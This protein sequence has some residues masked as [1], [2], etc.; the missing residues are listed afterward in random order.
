[1]KR[2]NPEKG[3][4]AMRKPDEKNTPREVSR[5]QFLSGSV[6]AVVATSAA[7]LGGASVAAYAQQSGKP[8]GG[9]QS[10]EPPGG[11]YNYTDG[12]TNEDVTWWKG[13]RVGGAS[14][15]VIQIPANLPMA[16]GNMGNASTFKFPVLYELLDVDPYKVF[17]AKA[18]AEVP[19]GIIQA[20]KKL[21][22]QGCRAIMGNCGFFGNYQTEVASKLKI[23]FY[24]SSL[25]QAPMIL[26]GI[27]SDQKLG[28]LTASRPN[29][30]KAPALKKC[31]VTDRSRVV[32]YGLENG[33]EWNI[34]LTEKGRY[35]LKR[36]EHELVALAREMVNKHPE[37]SA[38]LLEC[39][40][41]PSH[42]FAIQDA[43]R[44]PVWDFTTMMNW[45]HLGN[46]RRPFTGFI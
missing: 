17:S 41:M 26:N 23:P 27:G 16:P 28:I 46:V 11:L 13:R 1:M 7:V 12:Y 38:I 22:M 19:E 10:E 45:I 2:N 6:G 25:L 39:T 5:R 29:L 24:S 37:V 31:G 34:I 4:T 18:H 20:G 14:I 43:V 35:N 40:E 36:F 15:G 32:I 33:P 3:E 30:E 9:A 8:A 44:L 21:E 42:A